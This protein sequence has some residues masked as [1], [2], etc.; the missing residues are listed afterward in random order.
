MNGAPPLCG[1]ERSPHVHSRRCSTA[2]ALAATSPAQCTAHRRGRVCLRAGALAWINE[3]RART[4]A[5]D[6]A[7]PRARRACLAATP[8]LTPG[9]AKR[10][11]PQSRAGSSSAQH[12][13]TL[14]N[15]D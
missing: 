4:T 2:P 6:C 1:G 15:V 8:T 5:Q 3:L 14:Y 7:A 10:R 13:T 11:G 9:G 12:T